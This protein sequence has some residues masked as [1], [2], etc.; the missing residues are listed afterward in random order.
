MHCVTASDECNNVNHGLQKLRLYNPVLTAADDESHK[1]RSLALIFGS[2][3]IFG[4]TTR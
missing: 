1:L 2:D 4:A 3:T